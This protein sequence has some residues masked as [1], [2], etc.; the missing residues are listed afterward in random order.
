MAQL[1]QVSGGVAIEAAVFE[2]FEVGVGRDH[3]QNDVV[4]LDGSV[5]RRHARF[6]FDGKQWS[7]EDLESRNQT[8]VNGD[9]VES[10]AL[11]DDDRVQIGSVGFVVRGCRKPSFEVCPQS[12]SATRF[13]ESVATTRVGSIDLDARD[14]SHVRSHEARLVALYEVGK[15]VNAEIEKT[16]ELLERVLQAAIGEVSA[17]RGF[18][19][20]ANRE[21]SDLVEPELSMGRDGERIEDLVVPTTITSEVFGSHRSILTEDAVHDEVMSKSESIAASRILSAMCVPLLFRGEALGVLY[22]DNRAQASVFSKPDLEFLSCIADLAG[23]AL[24][25]ARLFGR[26]RDERNDL[27]ARLGREV[28]MIGESAAMR[29]VMEQISVVAPSDMTVL[30][31]GES[32]TGKEL[33]ARA[34]H[35]ESGRGDGPFV[36]VNCAAIPDT[37]IESELFGY[38]SHSGISGSAPQGKPGKFELAD[39]GTIFLDEI[40]DMRLDVQATILRVLQDGMVERLGGTKPVAVDVRVVAATNKE[41]EGAIAAGQFR[42]DLFYRLNRFSIHAPPLRDRPE[43]IEALARHFAQSYSRSKTP[44]RMTAKTLGILKRYAWPGNVREL[45]SVIERAL[46]FSDRSITP[47]ALPPNLA[48]G[49]SCFKTLEELQEEHI[50][51]VLHATGNVI[52]EAARI[53]GVSRK[54]LHEK[55]KRYEIETRGSS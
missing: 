23:A 47:D 41:L 4:L 22:V 2:G 49:P 9:P 48:G 15:R 19:A 35:H 39:G 10:H 54:T 12:D 53:L 34:I 5:S 8:R 24:G 29:S 13:G 14:F 50:R 32:G 43:D 40:G 17:E 33:V 1:I 27:R 36:P 31:T 11:E 16:D 45:E 20:L 38:A 55:V 28:S 37:L 30:V 26:V 21:G 18:I 52:A 7:V 44:P 3:K 25:N 42:Q 51:T 46:L 6:V